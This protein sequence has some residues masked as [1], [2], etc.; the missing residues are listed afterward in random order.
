[1]ALEL[2]QIKYASFLLYLETKHDRLLPY[3]NVVLK[4]VTTRIELLTLRKM[5]TKPFHHKFSSVIIYFGRKLQ[6]VIQQKMKHTENG[7]QGSWDGLHR[8]IRR[9]QAKLRALLIDIGVTAKKRFHKRKKLVLNSIPSILRMVCKEV[10]K[11]MMARTSW[12]DVI[13][14]I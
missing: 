9:A 2:L 11:L 14:M 4:S 6:D 3:D 1:M 10:L 12:H 8:S 5:K 13:F 7:K